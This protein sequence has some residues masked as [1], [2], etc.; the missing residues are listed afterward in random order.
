ME[1]IPCSWTAGTNTVKLSILCKE[2]VDL[3]N[4]KAYNSTEKPKKE[5][6]TLNAIKISVS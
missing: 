3:V 2:I 6:S 5:Q 1:D 4:A